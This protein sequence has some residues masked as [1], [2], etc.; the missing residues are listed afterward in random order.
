MMTHQTRFVGKRK[1]L[2][3]GCGKGY[4]LAALITPF[5]HWISKNRFFSRWL[6]LSFTYIAEKQ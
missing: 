5:D 2:D 4:L 3:P 6:A 1:I